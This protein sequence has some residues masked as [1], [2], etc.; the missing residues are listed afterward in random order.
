VSK[1]LQGFS[2]AALQLQGLVDVTPENPVSAIFE[3]GLGSQFE[4]FSG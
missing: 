3:Y 2:L 4:P 1:K